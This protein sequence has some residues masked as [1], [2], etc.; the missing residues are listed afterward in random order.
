MTRPYVGPVILADDDRMAQG[1][2]PAS[3]G[4]GRRRA[5]DPQIQGEPPPTC[6]LHR[7][8]ANAIDGMSRESATVSVE[9][10][11]LVTSA[12]ALASSV[13]AI[14]EE[15]MDRFDVV[16]LG[17]GSA[18]ELL[19]TFLA[20]AGR[21]VALVESLRVG[22]ECPYV[23]CM[24]SKAMLRGA[25]LH[26]EEVSLQDFV[27]TG[28]PPIRTDDVAFR[29]AVRR[30]DEISEHRDDHRAAAALQSAGVELIRGRGR[31]LRYG[32]VSVGDR[33]V[34]WTD[35]VLA[36]G[37]QPVIPNGV[38]LEGQPTWTSDQALS[39]S[40]RPSSVLV[41]GGGPVGC[42]LAQVFSRFGTATTLV[43]AGPQLAGREQAQVAER[44]A[45]VLAGDGID[46]RLD[47]T[48]LR[49]E[50]SDTGV[51]AS[52]S[53]GTTIDVERIIL[54]TGR[55]PTTGDLGLETLEIEVDGAGA[56][57]VD[58]HCRVTGTEHVWAAGDV[59]GLAPFTHTATYQA[60]IVVDNLLGGDRSA[61]YTAIPRA[62]YTDPP[63]AS[64]GRSVGPDTAEEGLLTATMDLDQTGRAAI[65]GPSN[66][67]LVLTAD[68]ALGVL[69]GAAAIGPRADE[70]L[71]EATLAIRAQIP[72]STLVDVVHAF[73]TY[74][75]AFEPA[76]RDL[77]AQ[78]L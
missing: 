48:V 47:T 68:R 21:T 11:K 53:D 74:G 67:I 1:Q 64:V 59:T 42:E 24:P 18:G 5:K 19:A 78:T 33:E 61:S 7:D 41:I 77:A 4:E 13:T 12:P 22:G 49:V 71:A 54:A 72:L 70:W 51:V 57:P 32:V 40:H 37:S 10:S 44:L 58:D 55:H 75:E 38:G 9:D 76:L 50:P 20:A 2:A 14:E 31:I 25:R 56:I 8:T 66:G 15:I 28:G 29:G 60:R 46:V 52:L 23:A 34:G 43:E 16:V 65:D 45:R 27:G 73:P 69:V 35:L 3:H 30:R 62:I 36:T 6:W 63:V 17:G 26:H 39:T